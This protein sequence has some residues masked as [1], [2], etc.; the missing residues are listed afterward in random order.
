MLPT[1]R[2]PSPAPSP[3][4]GLTT[5]P[6]TSRG[7]T[8]NPDLD[9]NR[10]I[11][12]QVIRCLLAPP[13][14]PPES[15][16]DLIHFSSSHSRFRHCFHPTPLT[17]MASALFCLPIS[18]TPCL[19]FLHPHSSLSTVL[20]SLPSLSSPQ[21]QSPSFLGSFTSSSPCP[22]PSKGPSGARGWNGGRRNGHGP[23]R[24]AA[25]SSW[26]GRRGAAAPWC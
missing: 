21:P 1:N 22:S 19:L 7:L 17:L 25:G 6:Q 24:K 13:V 2:L 18:T 5:K 9:C 12:F 8:P 15:A 4:W 14:F 11:K 26:A 3:S 20:F 10:H 16:P 23:L